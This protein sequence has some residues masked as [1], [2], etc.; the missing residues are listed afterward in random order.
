MK[1]AEKVISIHEDYKTLLD[2]V[3]SFLSKP[4]QKTKAVEDF[5]FDS[6]V[7]DFI[8]YKDYDSNGNLN[9]EDWSATLVCKDFVNSLLAYGE[10]EDVQIEDAQQ[11]APKIPEM[12]KGKSFQIDSFFGNVKDK[13]ST[14]RELIQDFIVE[15]KSSKY[16]D[17]KDILTV[18]VNIENASLD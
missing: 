8:G 14:S 18:E 11:L 16:D 2:I 10:G 5:F 12:I 3:K 1:L 13:R 15:V 6:D 7:S 9:L 4:N 17:G